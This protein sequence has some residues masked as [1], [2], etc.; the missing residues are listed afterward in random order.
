MDY[1]LVL[2]R[3][4][5][6][7]ATVSACGV[8]VF[9]VF[10]AEPVIA[11]AARSGSPSEWRTLYARLSRVFWFSLA[12]A[13]VADV[14][15]FIST[16]A[17]IADRPASQIFSDDVAWTV[18]TSTKFGH[19]WVLRLVLGVLLAASTWRGFDGKPIWQR[20]FQLLLAVGLVASLAWTGHADATPGLQ[21]D[22]HL[23]ADVLHLIAASAW[24]G[25]LLPYVL[26]LMAV[27]GGEA[28]SRAAAVKATQ[29]FSI[30]GIL[31]VETIFVT[32]FVNS[33]NLVGG[34]GALVATNYGRL[35]LV[36]IVLFLTMVGFA[37]VNRFC[38]AP[39]LALDGATRDLERN[40]L[41]EVA[42]GLLVLSIVGALGTLSP[43]IHEVMGHV[44]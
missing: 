42:L 36:K 16:V 18:L 15:W 4:L 11:T 31:A 19:V 34:F 33:W 32:G 43:A 17:G 23:V 22:V 8:V 10:I 26:F 13:F 40:S 5:H 39:R 38:L 21:G 1:A 27:R 29:R 44:H 24:L 37:A 20:L 30:L 6:F 12:L 28:S 9:A 25:G 7:A 2:A 35:L 41:I 3:A 14:A